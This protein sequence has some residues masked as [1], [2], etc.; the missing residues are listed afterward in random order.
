MT[1]EITITLD[2]GKKIALTYSELAELRRA[3]AIEEKANI[4][5]ME[6]IGCPVFDIQ[7]IPKFNAAGEDSP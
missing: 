7:K 4:D 3:L 5:E 6:S 2:S 1:V